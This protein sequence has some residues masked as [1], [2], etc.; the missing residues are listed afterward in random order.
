MLLW[1]SFLH[2]SIRRSLWLS[3]IETGGLVPFKRS[4]FALRSG[5]DTRLRRCGTQLSDGVAEVWG[6][7]LAEN[8]HASGLYRIS[9]TR[10]RKGRMA[11]WFGKNLWPN[12]PSRS[13]PAYK[14]AL[15]SP[16]TWAYSSPSPSSHRA[17]LP[18]PYHGSPT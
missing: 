16:P 12:C 11:P 17:W 14:A 3:K 7:G 5:L 15:L 18:E 13:P 2:W 6:G 1:C 4:E 8:G 10:W 9:E